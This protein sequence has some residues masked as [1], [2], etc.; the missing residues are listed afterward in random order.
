MTEPLVRVRDLVVRRG[1]FTLEVPAWEVPAGVVVGVVGPNGAGK[2]TLLR[3]LPGLDAR[4]AGEVR[5]L[6]LDPERRVAEVRARVG[7][8]SDE[9]PLFNLRVHRLLR[10][11]SGYYPTWDA[12]RVERL[13]DRFELDLGR[14]VRELSRG[15]GTRLR[16]VL[17]MAFRPRLLVLDEP[18]SGL[19]LAGRRALLATVLDVVRDE[20]CSVV[21]SSHLLSDLERVADRLLVL[22]RGRVLAEGATDALVPDGWNLEERMVAWGIAGEAGR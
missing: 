19:D 2:T 20:R 21:I 10:V 12:A 8:M 9:Q 6:G 3:L 15:Q 17:A 7:W 18:G 4:D 22:D 11:L 1:N 13:V 5:V 16:L 14:R